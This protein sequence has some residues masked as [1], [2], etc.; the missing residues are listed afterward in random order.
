MLIQTVNV[1]CENYQM[2]NAYH[3]STEQ[4]GNMKSGIL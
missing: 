2:K 1:Q 4:H 3:V